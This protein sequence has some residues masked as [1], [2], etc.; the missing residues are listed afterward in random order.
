MSARSQIFSAGEKVLQDALEQV[1]N[2]SF[3]RFSG[4]LTRTMSSIRSS[5]RRFR[6]A[7]RSGVP[8]VCACPRWPHLSPESHRLLSERQISCCWWH[9]RR[10]YHSA[11]SSWVHLLIFVQ[12]SVL[13]YPSLEPIALPI[14]LEKGEIYDAT[15]SSKTVSIILSMHSCRLHVP[16]S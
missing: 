2:R 12:L 4:M 6:L 7:E 13:D 9:A 5:L 15:F 16:F 8:C 14:R 3:T 10:T 11:P 1:R